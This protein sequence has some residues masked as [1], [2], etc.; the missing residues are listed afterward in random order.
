M[1]AEGDVLNDLFIHAQLIGTKAF[2]HIAVEINF[3]HQ[4]SP[5]KM[6]VFAAKRRPSQRPIT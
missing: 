2:T 1:L 5:F 6:K 4:V 3:F